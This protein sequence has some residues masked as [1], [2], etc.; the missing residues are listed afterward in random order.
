MIQLTL[1]N[2]YHH[3]HL[4]GHGDAVRDVA[5]QGRIA[6]SGSYD[7]TVRVWDIITG[8]CKWILSGHTQKGQQS[9]LSS[10]SSVYN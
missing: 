5:A 9:P 1:Q 3:H 4:E 7:C 10:V 8:E 2:P 6:V